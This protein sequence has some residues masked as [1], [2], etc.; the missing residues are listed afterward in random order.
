MENRQKKKE[1]LNTVIIIILAFILPAIARAGR[2]KLGNN[3]EFIL[4]KD[5][6]INLPSIGIYLVL[7]FGSLTTI[8]MYIIHISVKKSVLKY[9]RKKYC[10]E[11]ILCFYNPMIK[12]LVIFSFIVGAL[13][14]THFFPFLI[15]EDITHLDFIT[16][17]NV[18]FY[19]LYVIFA[20]IGLQGLCGYTVIL[21]D[22]RLIG[23]YK[24]YGENIVL[25]KDIK[26]IKKTPLGYEVITNYN[27]MFPLKQHKKQM[28]V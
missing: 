9:Y 7:I 11:N 12:A 15:S 22:K 16:R 25:L 14:G 23:T 17:E 3:P 4:V 21:T 18:L 26:E 20:L 19:F 10:N 1:I 2:Y 13:L 27:F 6:I 8:L 5:N 28:S 24:W